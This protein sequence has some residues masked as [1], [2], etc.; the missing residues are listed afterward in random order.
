LKRAH[1]LGSIF[2]TDIVNFTSISESLPIEKLTALLTEYF[3]LLTK[4]ILDC[5]GTIDKY[6]GDSIMSIWGAPEDL[7]DFSAQACKAA[8]LCQ[9]RLAALHQ[10]W[11]KKR[12]SSSRRKW[13]SKRVLCS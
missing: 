4:V 6:I 12:S 9:H 7:T 2:F 11:E 3:E 8:L 10:E 5:G 13:G 1:P